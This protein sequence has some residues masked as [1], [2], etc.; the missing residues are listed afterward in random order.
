MQENERGLWQRYK[1]EYKKQNALPLPVWRFWLSLFVLIFALA[2][3]FLLIVS[4]GGMVG[5]VA[6]LAVLIVAFVIYDKRPDIYRSS[7]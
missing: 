6:L 5:V 7:F 3:S 2:L 4:G 1:A